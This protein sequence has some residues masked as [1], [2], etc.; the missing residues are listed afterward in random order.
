MPHTT[1]ITPNQSNADS[2]LQ[3]AQATARTVNLGWWLQILSLPLALF[4]ILAAATVLFLRYYDRLT[5]C[6]G[7]ILAIVAAICLIGFVC[8]LSAKRKFE[9]PEES[10]VRIEEKM[11]LRNALT[12]ARAGVAPWPNQTPEKVQT[13]LKW[14]LPR[15]IIPP[16]CSIIL[17]VAAFYIPIGSH[18]Q[19]LAKK[20]VP[21][22]L[23]D[24]EAQLQEL[25][26]EDIVQDDY[27][28]EMEEQVQE[29]KQQDPDEWFSHSSLEAI[30]HLKQNHENAAKLAQQNLKKAER[31]LQNLQKHGDKLDQATKQGL[32]NEF[33]KAVEDLDA[34]SMKPNRELLEQLKNID[35]KQLDQLTPEQLNELRENM[36]NMAEK[37]QQQA[38]DDAGENG[39]GDGDGDKSGEDG[40]GDGNGNHSDNGNSKG[41]I[42]RGPGHNEHLMGNEADKLGLGKHERIKPKDLSNTLPGDL[43]ETTDGE[44]KVDKTDAKIRNGGTTKHK[45]D[46]GERVWKN[47]LLPNEKKALKQFFK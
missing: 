47:S 35:P 29:I 15:T 21:S 19:E 46:G 39:Q 17:I 2:W 8:Y 40:E 5:S 10:L 18:A 7:L 42:S 24:L 28:E 4:S 38:G 9:T 41:G 34:G 22:S 23:A 45:G 25:K 26:D 33:A 36:R 12:A 37:L 43:L 13:G 16:L 27:I 32:L 11:K 1:T 3:Q 44:H 20:P 6:T 31:A 30:D 14:N